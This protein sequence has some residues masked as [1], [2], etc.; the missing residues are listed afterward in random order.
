MHVSRTLTFISLNARSEE[1]STT[2]D[3]AILK[4][5]VLWT[6]VTRPPILASNRNVAVE[7]FSR[8]TCDENKWPFNSEYHKNLNSGLTR[9]VTIG[10][11][12]AINSSRL[13]ARLSNGLGLLK[14]GSSWPNE[15]DV[16]LYISTI[17]KSV[18]DE[19]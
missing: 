9:L 2:A 14:C 12:Q 16:S 3:P 5:P 8:I 19:I 11:W 17:F 15:G 4:L 1:R 18:A 6:C 7:I 10:H 13:F